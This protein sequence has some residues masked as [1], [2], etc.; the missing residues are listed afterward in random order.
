LSDTHPIL[1]AVAAWKPALVSQQELRDRAEVHL[2]PFTRALTLDADTSEIRT[3]IR[4]LESAHN[5][6]RLPTSTRILGPLQIESGKSRIV[7]TAPIHDGENLV[8]LVHEFQRRRSISRKT[9]ASLRIDPY[10][11]TR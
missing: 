3:I 8:E 5:Q 2:P 4:G 6:G 1:G 7:V 11:L 9:L 10:S